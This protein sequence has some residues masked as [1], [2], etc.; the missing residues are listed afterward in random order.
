MLLEALRQPGDGHRHAGGVG[1]DVRVGDG[2]A[3]GRRASVR[4]RSRGASGATSI[5]VTPSPR[6][7]P[8]VSARPGLEPEPVDH[9]DVGAAHVRRLAR[10]TR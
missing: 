1:E 2:G 10:R 4:V 3:R 8:M 6:A 5:T 7:A 9:E